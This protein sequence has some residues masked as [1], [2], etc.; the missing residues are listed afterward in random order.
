MQ[1]IAMITGIAKI[2]GVPP[3]LL[4]AVCMTET[5]LTNAML[6]HDGNS[7]TYGVCQ[8]KAGTAFDLGYKGSPEGLMEP[9]TNVLY[10]AKYLK[11]QLDRYDGNFCKSISAYNAG[12]YIESQNSP[13]YPKNLR[14]VRNVQK[15]LAVELQY[16]LS[17]YEE[18]AEE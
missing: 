16:M 9:K 1:Y 18:V 13:G 5:N 17:C 3:Y 8:I 6:K 14:Y 10:A 12:S 7:P 15:N 2:V 4:L 11:Y